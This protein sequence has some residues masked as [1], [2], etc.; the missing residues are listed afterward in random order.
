M[1]ILVF[2]E[3]D[4]NIERFLLPCIWF[5]HSNHTY[6]HQKPNKLSTSL[7][8]KRFHI[9]RH[10]MRL[11]GFLYSSTLQ[12]DTRSLTNRNVNTHSLIAVAKSLSAFSFTLW[13]RIRTGQKSGMKWRLTHAQ[14]QAHK[15]NECKRQQL[16]QL[17]RWRRDYG[18]RRN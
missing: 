13:F 16:R 6:V 15:R 1:I 14:A 11:R 10:K 9:R 18:R 7:H 12:T 5:F 17:R 3:L 2:A 4:M 8:R